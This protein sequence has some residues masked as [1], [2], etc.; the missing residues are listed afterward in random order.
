MLRWRLLDVPLERDE[1]GYAYIAWQWA[2]DGIP[3]KD[4][5]D[6]KPPVIFSLYWISHL[7]FGETTR[8]IHL[9][10]SLWVTLTT[11]LLYKLTE[12]LF[13]RGA[14]LVSAAIFVVICI[15]PVV[16][17]HSFNTEIAMLLPII[18]SFYLLIIWIER[19]GHHLVFLSGV[20]S[21]IAFMTK[22]PAI[23]NAIFLGLIILWE[24]F[25]SS[26]KR[27]AKSIPITFF[28]VG[29]VSFPVIYGIYFWHL[30]VVNEFMAGSFFQGIEYIQTVEI[31]F[32]YSMMKQSLSRIGS[33]YAVLLAAVLVASVYG[34]YKKD[35][36]FLIVFGW[37]LFSFS[38]VIA[39]KLFQGHYFL[40][41]FPS[42]ALII[43][44]LFC[45]LQKYF[46]RGIF[47]YIAIVLIS[48][49]IGTPLLV[50]ARS[51]FTDSP[52]KISRKIHNFNPFVESERIAEYIRANTDANETVLILGSEPQILYLAKRKS[53]IRY[54]FIYPL[55]R[56][57]SNVIKKHE[58]AWQEVKINNPAYIVIV[59]VPTS[60]SL[61]SKSEQFFYNNVYKLNTNNYYLDGKVVIYPDKTDYFFGKEN[62]QKGPTKF[63][64]GV[65]LYRRK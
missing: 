35:K 59:Y 47:K 21:G 41:V 3:Y 60:H 23:I 36:Y 48:L 58:L 54:I 15:Q 51:L 1:G 5:F 49:L 26:E 7:I 43:G 24:C 53:A 42:C 9:F 20:F 65:H 28:F 55:N 29:F 34:F 17:G 6:Q 27:I 38:G 40:Q 22:Q 11:L 64:Y 57:Y 33:T 30:G 16:E 62:V 4:A 31:K 13:R 61:T 63:H 45:S 39:Q 18:L 19:R 14:A 25:K 32:V 10:L 46:E 37:F 44:F 52:D 12:R 2:N 56:P 50:N 8:G